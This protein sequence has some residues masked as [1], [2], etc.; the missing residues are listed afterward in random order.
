MSIDSR[1]Y[2]ENDR[3]IQE[4]VDSE[5]RLAIDESWGVARIVWKYKGKQLQNRYHFDTS[6]K[7]HK[8]RYTGSAIIEWDYNGDCTQETHYDEDFKLINNRAN[9]AAI[10]KWIIRDNFYEKKFYDIN[11]ELTKDYQTQVAIIRHEQKHD[12]IIFSYFDENKKL[13][14]NKC[15]QAARIESDIIEKDGFVYKEDVYY[16]KKLEPL[17]IKKSKYKSRI[18]EDDLLL[19]ES[20]HDCNMNLLNTKI[21]VSDKVDCKVAIIRYQ[22]DD[23]YE[24][25]ISIYYN[26]KLQKINPT[27]NS[28]L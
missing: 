9:N 22:Y 17:Y 13:C 24:D 3:F 8:N 16:N 1:Y 10:I 21:T 19:E 2:R 7:L 26:S 5:N 6:N 4:F 28:N 18:D 20:Y 12:K 27:I 14:R 11:F 23:H 25:P 15:C